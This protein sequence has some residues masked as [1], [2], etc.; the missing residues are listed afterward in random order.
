MDTAMNESVSLCT[1]NGYVPDA[2]QFAKR[3]TEDQAVSY[4]PATSTGITT[5]WSQL[6]RLSMLLSCFDKADVSAAFESRNL[7][8]RQV[9]GVRVEAHIFFQVMF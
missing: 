5:G 6:R 1:R 8:F 4:H 7:Y 2:Y 3:G 9:L